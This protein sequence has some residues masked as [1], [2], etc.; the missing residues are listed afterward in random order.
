MKKAIIVLIWLALSYG[1]AFGQAECPKSFRFVFMTDIHVQPERHA[2]EGLQ[3]AIRCVNREHPDFVVTGGDL[4]YDALGVRYSRADSLY[5]IYSS[6]MKGLQMPLWNTIGN[7][8][9]FGV[10]RRSGPDTLHPMRGTRLFE[11]RIGKPYQSFT[12]KGWKFFLL[13]SVRINGNRT[14]SGFIDPVQTEWIKS[15]LSETDSATPI[16]IVT[17][18]PLR[19]VFPQVTDSAR[20]PCGPLDVIS[21]ANAVL[22]LFTEHNLKLVLQ[23]H[24]HYR[25]EIFVENIWFVTGGSVAA[26]WWTGPY[27]GVPEGYLVVRTKKDQ[28]SWKYKPYGWTALK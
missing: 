22:R 2:A 13:N 3:K 1:V 7:H 27:R 11:D 26:A 23:G 16:I 20:A 10:Y 6:A 25:E 4:V 8:E 19:T 5:N 14:Y 18:I 21:N 28:V 9:H 12:H 17:H 24:M 15:E